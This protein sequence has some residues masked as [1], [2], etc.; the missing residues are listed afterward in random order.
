MALVLVLLCS[1]ISVDFDFL[2]LFNFVCGS[3]SIV[4]NHIFVANT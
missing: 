2:S 4:H 3:V 1:T